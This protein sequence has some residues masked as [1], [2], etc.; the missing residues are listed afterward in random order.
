MDLQEG[1]VVCVEIG[2]EMTGLAVVVARWRLDWSALLAADRAD[3]WQ[4]VDPQMGYLLPALPLA[5]LASLAD[6]FP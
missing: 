6:A 1:K 4:A 3:A 2:M 5:S